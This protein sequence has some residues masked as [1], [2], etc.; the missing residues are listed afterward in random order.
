MTISFLCCQLP[1]DFPTVPTPL[2][3]KVFEHLVTFRFGRFMERSGALRT[4]QFAYRKG[5]GTC[6]VLLCMSHTLQMTLESG[7]EAGIVQIGFIAAIDT[8]NNQ[9]ILH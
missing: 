7:Q 5:L 6:V 3:S 2:L 8:V 9:R 4:T 1:T